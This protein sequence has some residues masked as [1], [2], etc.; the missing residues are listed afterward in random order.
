M[1]KVLGYVAV[2]C[3]S[4]ILGYQTHKHKKQIQTT[5]KAIKQAIKIKVAKW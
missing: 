4:A 5:K 1:W 2:A 3:G